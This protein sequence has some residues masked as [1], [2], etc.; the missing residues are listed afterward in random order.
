VAAP[1]SILVI[2]A[3]TSCPDAEVRRYVAAIQAF[4]PH[5]NRA[6]SLP[7]VDLAFMPHGQA[8]PDGFGHL[9]IVADNSD[10]ARALGYHEVAPSGFPIGYT[11]AETAR[12]H[13][14]AVSAVLTHEV[15]EARVN[16]LIDRVVIGPDGRRWFLEVADAPEAD[17]WGI[18]WPMPDRSIVLLSNFCLPRY[19]EFGAPEGPAY[20]YL[21]HLRQPIPALLPGGYLAFQEPGGAYGQITAFASAMERARAR[22]QPYGRRYRAMM[23]D[24]EPSEAP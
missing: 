11:F 2:N 21:G 1:E 3:A 24:W 10:Q 14:S 6:W 5:F 8:I 18:R 19:F 20:D 22:P 12:Q 17:Q 4:M 9:Q 13:G 16:P 23:R 7:E 15:W